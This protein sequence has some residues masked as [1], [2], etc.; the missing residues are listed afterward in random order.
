MQQP[1]TCSS[2]IEN[3]NSVPRSGFEKQFIDQLK[4]GQ[5]LHIETRD[6]KPRYRKQW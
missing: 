3:L 6:G 1:C 4:S 2:C 5:V